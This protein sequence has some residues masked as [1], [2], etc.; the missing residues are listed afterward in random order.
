[1][2]EALEQFVIGPGVITDHCDHL[3]LFKFWLLV[4]AIGRHLQTDINAKVKF[5]T[6]RKLEA[7]SARMRLPVFRT[8]FPHVSG[9]S[10]CT[11]LMSAPLLTHAS[12]RFAYR[13]K[14]LSRNTVRVKL[15]MIITR[16]TVVTY[17]TKNGLI[18]GFLTCPG[19]AF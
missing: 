6:R 8:N 17:P 19:R 13:S 15:T 10:D 14:R 7:V 4:E 18:F 9:T 5:V 1:M 2:A 11:V 16:S 3:R 12:S